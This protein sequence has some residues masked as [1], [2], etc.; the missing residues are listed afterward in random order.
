MITPKDFVDRWSKSELREQQAAQSHF[1]EL[2]QLVGHK[3]PTQIDP[4]GTFFTFEE[5]VFKATGGKGRADVWY[6]GHFAWEYKGKHKDL[7]AA[8]AQLLAY[9]G[10]L[11]NPPLLVVC[12]FLEYRIYP[13]W[14][15]T[16]GIPFVFHN[17]DL[18][19]EDTLRYIRW[20]L[21]DPNRFLELRQNE[22]ERRE[23]I[24][25]D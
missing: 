2:C 5:N 11:D 15:N 8:Y 1:N 4:E 25:L 9:K 23:Q 17:E 3:T 19:H 7:D 24:T 10:D 16:S 20:L 21:E 6:K 12:D 14:T 22:L 18:L 13:Q